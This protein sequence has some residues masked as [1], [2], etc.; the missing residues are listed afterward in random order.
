M[1]SQ[2]SPYYTLSIKSLEKISAFCQMSGSSGT[3]FKVFI[4]DDTSSTVWS[5]LRHD[6]D[7]CS[8]DNSQKRH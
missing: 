6:G 3:P 2:V 4:V 1:T 5:G 8:L 7:L